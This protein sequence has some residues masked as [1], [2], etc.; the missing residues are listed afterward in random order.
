MMSRQSVTGLVL[1]GL[2]APGCGGGTP[3]TGEMAVQPADYKKKEKAVM[4]GFLQA[5]KDQ[6]AAKTKKGR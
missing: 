3:K 6:M 2:L 5:K 4:E 1:A